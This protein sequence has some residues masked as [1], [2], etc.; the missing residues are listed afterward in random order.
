MEYLRG[1]WGILFGFV[2]IFLSGSSFAEPWVVDEATF[3][4]NQDQ[5]RMSLANPGDF[6]EISTTETGFRLRV[7]KLGLAVVHG[8]TRVSIFGRGSR[9][10]RSAVSAGGTANFEY[11]T[12]I[13]TTKAQIPVNDLW[14]RVNLPRNPS[15]SLQLQTKEGTSVRV[16]SE[17]VRK[18]LSNHARDHGYR[19][20]TQDAFAQLK[21]DGNQT[22]AELREE[23]F[24]F[25]DQ[26]DM[27][28]LFE[29][30]QD[31]L[32]RY[33][34]E[35]DREAYLARIRDELARLDMT[36]RDLAD[37]YLG[38]WRE[39]LESV[40]EVE[41]NAAVKID[42]DIKL[43]PSDWDMDIENEELGFFLAFRALDDQEKT[44]V[45]EFRSGVSRVSTEASFYVFEVVAQAEGRVDVEASATGLENG[46]DVWSDSVRFGGSGSVEI[47]L[48]LSSHPLFLS[49]PKREYTLVHVGMGYFLKDTTQFEIEFAYRANGHRRHQLERAKLF[50]S[51]QVA[52]W[53]AFHMGGSYRQIASQTHFSNQ[54]VPGDLLKQSEVDNLN[55][56]LEEYRDYIGDVS[57]T[58]GIALGKNLSLDVADLRVLGPNVWA[59]TGVTTQ[60]LGLEC[61]AHWEQYRFLLGG[62]TNGFSPEDLFRQAGIDPEIFGDEVVMDGRYVVDSDQI[63][64]NRYLFGVGL[65]R[66]K[67][68]VRPAIEVGKGRLRG[69]QL[70][71]A[72][73]KITLS[74]DRCVDV[75]FGIRFDLDQDDVGAFRISV[76]TAR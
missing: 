20:A 55:R 67:W 52:P 19:V 12:G 48:D 64:D 62:N 18:Y 7:W 35:V 43:G 71:S 23:L 24:N 8:E 2:W 33:V 56:D 26:V 38:Q 11:E 22:Y 50:F 58:F 51:Q 54:N 6:A 46:E 4:Y 76:G 31:E 1:N 34:P 49:S 17:A 32:A 63:I 16:P 75:N 74:R 9:A 14:D 68:A 29:G 39:R 27:G 72:L 61:R 69:L 59:K 70:E 30:V 41:F 40:D 25:W 45:L 44:G 53:M 73:K 57:L 66:E 21:S 3:F 15:S 10:F 37:E 60:A 36:Y 65:N 13:E 5:R 42:Y 28:R 47:P